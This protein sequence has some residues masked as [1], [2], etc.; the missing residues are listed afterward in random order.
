M[1]NP[2]HPT[3]RNSKKIVLG[4]DPGIANTG[5]GVVEFH[6]NRF[7]PRAFGNITTSPQTASEMRLKKIYDAVTDLIAE[8][9]IESVVLEDIFFSKN[10]N[11]AFTLGEVK[12]IV[13]LAAA[14]A[15]CPIAAIRADSGQTSHRR[16]WES[17]KSADAKNDTSP[18]ET[19]RA[20]TS[21]SRSRRAR[22]C[23]LPCP[24]L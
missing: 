18:A 2:P 4:I 20:A 7:T 14:N 6:A 21:G 1:Q 9:A 8:F 12:G 5:Y 23:R 22:A 13:K 16:L 3:A 24:F 15:N 17:H 11:S 19:K 10:I